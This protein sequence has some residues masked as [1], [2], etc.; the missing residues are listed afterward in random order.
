MYAIILCIRDRVNRSDLVGL[1]W[2]CMPDL[3]LVVDLVTM[4][5]MRP[6]GKLASELIKLSL[7]LASYLL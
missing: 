5:A 7:A 3:L 1:A 2:S 4:P 6:S